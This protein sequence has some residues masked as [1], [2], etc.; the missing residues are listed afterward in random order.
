MTGL[1]AALFGTAATS[2]GVAIGTTGALAFTAAAPATAGLIGVGGVAS[3]GGTAFSLGNA[4]SVGSG[5]FQAASA[6]SQGNTQAAI[7]RNQA[8]E[9]QQLATQKRQIAAV[10]ATAQERANMQAFKTRTALLG[11]SGI[12]LNTGTPLLVSIDIAGR[13]K[14]EEEKIRF[15]GEQDALAEESRARIFQAQSGSFKRAGFTRA[16]AAL[17]TTGKEVFA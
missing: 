14:E 9:R 17:L 11:G 6:I 15:Q 10:N 8:I 13:F 5:I 2:G 16:G 12:E 4:F 1:E 3:F 7:A